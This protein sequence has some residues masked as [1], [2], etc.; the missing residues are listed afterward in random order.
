MILRGCSF[1][2]ILLASA[3]PVWAAAETADASADAVDQPEIVVTGQRSEYGARSTSTATKTVTEVRNIPQALTTIT[4]AQ[5]EDQQLRSVADLLY[6]VPG[7]TPGT[8]EGNRDQMTLRG[9]NSTADFFVDGVRDDVQYFRDFYNVG[10]VEVLRGSNAMIFGRGGGGGVVNRVTKRSSL[11]PYRQFIGSTGSDGGARFTGDVDQPLGAGLGLRVNGLYEDGNSFRRHVDLQRYGINPTLAYVPGSSIRIDVGFEYLHDRRTADR[12]VP[13]RDG[14]P[15]RGFDR[16]F[17]GDP[18]K[19]FSKADVSLATATLEHQFMPEL[20]LRS[21]ARFGDYDKFYQNIYPSKLEGSTVT[22]G[23]YNSENS[24]RNL[25]NQTDLVWTGRVGGVDQTLLFGFE[26]GKQTS[27]NHRMS[28]TI[29]GG[30]TTDLAAATVDRDV[31]FASTASDAD[32]RTRATVGALYVQDQIRPADWLEIVAGL[33]FDSFKLH[34]DDLRDGGAEFD[35][36]DTLW[37]PRLGVVLKPSQRL[38]LYGSYSRSFLPQSGDQ[39]SG[40]SPVTDSLKPEKFDNVEAGAKWEPVEGLLATAAVYQLDRTNTRATDPLT[41]LTV[42]T[43]AQRTRGIELGLERSISN[44]WQISAGYALQKAE[45][46]RTT[47]SAPEGRE[48]P[49][50]PR[51]TFSLW[52][53]YDAN[54]QLGFGLGLV[55]RSKS[56]ASISNDV[57]LPGYARVDA[58][59]FYKVARG[60]EAQL[61]LENAFNAD[62][63]PTAHNDN[64][65]APGAPRSL[66]ATLRYGF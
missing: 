9:N 62:Y 22:L 45:I 66:K 26:V 23:A 65:I 29:T 64:N 10:R 7:A 46:T 15:L 8:G 27:R 12:G 49:L 63:F 43:G 51:H 35:R 53:R 2:A 40:L 38:S 28:G 50:V 18:D 14:E 6:F 30:N 1:A 36:R 31:L 54:K 25:F 48:V 55:A 52:S 47:A 11:N 44:R 3:S 41:Q 39:F 24:R 19:S 33:R 21:R 34:V 58:A 57:T 17:F 20:T 61:N 5:I 16:T 42:L 56:Y 32:N 37:S 59:L 4:E 13:A 60:I